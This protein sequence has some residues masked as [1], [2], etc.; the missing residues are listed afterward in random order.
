MGQVVADGSS[1]VQ[2]NALCPYSQAPFGY[3]VMLLLSAVIALF[4]VFLFK[5]RRLQMRIATLN[6]L[7]VIISYG[8]LFVYRSMTIGSTIFLLGIVNFLPLAA[9]FLL[10]L[11]IQGIRHDE[12][13]I[14]SLDR[15][16]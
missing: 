12:K 13:L 3:G 1:F 10:A 5:N 16:R 14:R 6:I 4:N 15:I 7:L 8:V 11:A 9:L 2:F